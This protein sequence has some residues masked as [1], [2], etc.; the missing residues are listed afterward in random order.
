M[1]CKQ[2]DLAG[3]PPKAAEKQMF[4]WPF[5]EIGGRIWVLRIPKAGLRAAYGNDV[6][7]DCPAWL[8]AALK[9]I[10]E[11]DRQQERMRVSNT[12][13]REQDDM[14]RVCDVLREAGGAYYR[15]WRDCPQ[16]V[17]LGL[18]E[19]ITGR[20]DVVPRENPNHMW[21]WKEGHE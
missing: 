2:A 19:P 6:D 20:N 8:E 15:G 17:E 21:K 14:D 12:R 1:V 13:M 11:S 7:R 9:E 5:E 10:E 16:V 4:G 3:L 18:L